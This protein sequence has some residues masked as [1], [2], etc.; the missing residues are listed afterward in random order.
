MGS[1]RTHI[2]RFVESDLDAR[3]DARVAP[4]H[5]KEDAINAARLTRFRFAGLMPG[6]AVKGSRHSAAIAK[7]GTRRR[8]SGATNPA[9][10]A[11][12]MEQMPFKP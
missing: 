9:M 2:E 1:S 4:R 11:R 10:T 8:A 12:L 5:L 3:I 7:N 6:S